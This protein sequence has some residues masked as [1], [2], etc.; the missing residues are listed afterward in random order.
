M[1]DEKIPGD[2]VASSNATAASA[3]G[4]GV[5][6]DPTTAGTLAASAAGNAAASAADV[7]GLFDHLQQ[8]LDQLPDMQALSERLARSRAAAEVL[9]HERELKAR[10]SMLAGTERHMEEARQAIEDARAKG[11]AEEADPDPRRQEELQGALLYWAQKHGLRVGPVKNARAALEKALASG[12]FDSVEDAR[13]A[14]LA[15]DEAEQIAGDV[16]RYQHDYEETLATCQAIEDREGA[17]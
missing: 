6:D 5:A 17:K 14:L 13:Q 9:A 12:G 3:A 16:A 4:D 8:L 2:E 1:A 15:D 11:A 7:D 10:E